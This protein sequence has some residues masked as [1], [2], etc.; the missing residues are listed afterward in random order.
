LA[1]NVKVTEPASGIPIA[2]DDI[3]GIQYQ[4]V[5]VALGADGSYDT[6]VDSGQQLMVNSLPVVIASD[7]GA[8]P[9]TISTSLPS[10]SANLGSININTQ[11]GLLSPSNST[12]SILGAGGTFTGTGQ[13]ALGYTAIT[14]FVATNQNGTIYIEQSQNGTIW[15]ISDSF[16]V[17]GSTSFLT[18]VQL[19][20]EF[21]R[22]RYVNGS[23]IQGYF[24]LESILRPIYS[25]LPRKLTQGGNLKVAIA[26]PSVTASSP[27]VG[28]AS[29][30]AIAA[31]SSTDLD[32]P[33]ITVG[34]TAHLMQVIVSSSVPFKAE[35]KK[36][37]NA[38][39][40]A[41]GVVWV[42][43]NRGWHWKSPGK[44]FITQ[45]YDAGVG[46]D[47]FRVT[48]TSLDTGAAADIY[49]S[50]FYDEV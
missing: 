17:T 47:G 6:D 23:T 22:V 19:D 41:T 33:Q 24:R 5:K 40:T 18:G 49:A 39:A 37:A 48:A 34:K 20:G 21:V 2:A 11:L 35:I 38:V 13:S 12:T 31:G 28:S 7:Q 14:V 42:E 1:D 16:T 27:K 9:I 50:F 29:D 32:S 44:G 8:V 4:R 30:I 3:G 36:L 43:S 45:A 25:V 15:D 26:E 10:G 46:L